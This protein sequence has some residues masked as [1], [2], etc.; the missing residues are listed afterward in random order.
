MTGAV[1]GPDPE[2][3]A[4][5]L[6]HIAI[7]T[8][9]SE[10]TPYFV[11]M[12]SERVTSGMGNLDLLERMV[13]MLEAL[14]GNAEVDISPYIHQMMPTILTVLVAKRLSPPDQDHW[15]LRRRAAKLVARIF[16]EH[17]AKYP[18]IQ[19][20]TTRTLLKA[21]LDP[22]KPRVTHFGAVVG[23]G[24]LGRETVRM[25]VLPS[26]QAFGVALEQELSDPSNPGP[27]EKAQDAKHFFDA[28]VVSWV[29][30]VPCGCFANSCPS[31][32]N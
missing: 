28:V 5:A 25:L 14:L 12:A 27:D 32:F 9:I 23:L 17:G 13:G 16:R 2:M 6:K 22:L 20:R 26:I 29:W 1:L 24:E 19:P 4:E 18:S 7:D 11:Q 10:L 8:G 21:S 3:R 31:S 30:K 15:S